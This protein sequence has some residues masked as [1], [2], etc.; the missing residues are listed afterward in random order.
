MPSFTNSAPKEARIEEEKE[1]IR[2]KVPL[3]R[4]GYSGKV[5]SAPYERQSGTYPI[6][7]NPRMPNKTKMR[8]FFS[9]NKINDVIIIIAHERTEN[10]IAFIDLLYQPVLS[11][12]IPTVTAPRIPVNNK[13]RPNIASSVAEKLKGVKILDMSVPTAYIEPKGRANAITSSK[14]FRFEKIALNA[15]LKSNAS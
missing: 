3:I 4:G 10:P 5:S 15:D 1:P 12:T 2:V 14:K 6:A 8:N 9:W 13:I 11:I 7:Q